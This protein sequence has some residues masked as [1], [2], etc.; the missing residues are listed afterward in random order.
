MSVGKTLFAQ[1]MEFVLW[2]TFGRIFV[3]PLCGHWRQHLATE[4]APVA[5]SQAPPA[6]WAEQEFGAA[7]LPETR[8]KRR[9]L[10]LARDFYARPSANVPQACGSRARAKAAYRFF[11]HAQTRMETLLASYYEATAQRIGREQVV[12]AVQDSTS[13]NYTAHAATEGLGRICNASMTPPKRAW[14][15]RAMRHI[16]A[17]PAEMILG[18]DQRSMQGPSRRPT[19]GRS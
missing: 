7:Q 11:D 1:V 6:D 16:V 10:T 8:L 19:F 12:L 18:K 14:S 17:C 5:T 4:G 15:S 3:R 9:L 13:L 2:K